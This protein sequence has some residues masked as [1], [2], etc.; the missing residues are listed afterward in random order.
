MSSYYIILY[1]THSTI[2]TSEHSKFQAPLLQWPGDSSYRMYTTTSSRLP[3]QAISFILCCFVS[4]LIL[5]VSVLT[6]SLKS[7]LSPF[8]VNVIVGI[9][10]TIVND[11]LMMGCSILTDRENYRNTAS[12]ITS[13]YGKYFP[14]Q[15][16]SM[17][18]PLVTIGIFKPLV[19]IKW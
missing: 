5:V 19:G 16:L 8:I 1:H 15:L 13:L 2:T 12:Y 9:L 10:I 14:L 17:I 6:N 3:N 11:I 4:F 7:F 18:A